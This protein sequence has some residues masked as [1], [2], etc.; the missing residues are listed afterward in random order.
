MKWIKSTTLI[1]ALIASFPTFT[2]AQNACYPQFI[3]SV[4]NF[5]NEK[6]ETRL[7]L[8]NNSLQE[9][10]NICNPDKV[11]AYGLDIEKLKADV[12]IIKATPQVAGNTT[13]I[14]N[15]SIIASTTVA[16]LEVLLPSVSIWDSLMTTVTN[17]I[18]S[19]SATTT[20]LQAQIDALVTG[21]ISTA[22]IVS[23][24]SS[25]TD[26]A[27]LQ[28]QINVSNGLISGNRLD[29]DTATTTLANSIASIQNTLNNLPTST[30]L[31]ALTSLQ[32]QIN[33][34]PTTTEL[35]ASSTLSIGKLTIATTVTPTNNIFTVTA[36]STGTLN[37]EQVLFNFNGLT[38]GNGFYTKSS[39]LTTGTLVGILS[40]SPSGLSAPGGVVGSLLDVRHTGTGSLV[41]DIAVIAKTNTTGSGNVLSIIANS[42]TALNIVGTTTGFSIKFGSG[43]IQI[44][45]T[46]N[47]PLGTATLV[48]GIIVVANK[49]ITASSRVFLSNANA[50]G[51]PGIVYVSAKSAGISFTITSTSNTDASTINYLI[52]N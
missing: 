7:T 40:T 16:D 32:N 10:K 4:G 12:A 34:I 2:L 13:N 18:T 14:S 46:V 17:S 49:A 15:S 45:E 20:S 27:N 23:I 37:A 3:E 31:G 51:T 22:T 21:T 30:S 24:V 39:T 35:G 26:I 44:T 36:S 43:K 19:A 8:V 5:L 42:G 25:S 6:V 28:G 11:S 47:S 52:I 9:V 41:G 50:S 29:L 38:V 1:I 33:A 48:N